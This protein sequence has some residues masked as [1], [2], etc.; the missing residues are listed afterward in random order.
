M[1]SKKCVTM[2][3][4]IKQHQLSYMCG[5]LEMISI[6]RMTRRAKYFVEFMFYSS[7]VLNNSK[8]Y[9]KDNL[10]IWNTFSCFFI[11]TIKKGQEMIRLKIRF[12]VKLNSILESGQF[13][14]PMVE[15][16]VMSLIF[17]LPQQT[18]YYFL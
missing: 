11:G 8:G 1:T 7:Q 13:P 18:R 6:R 5:L 9:Q 3:L 2:F 12:P 14:P 15:T 4:L 17:H 16:C 10:L